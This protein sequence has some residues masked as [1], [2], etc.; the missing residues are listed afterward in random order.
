MA[1]MD[2]LYRPACVP[3]GPTFYVAN[4]SN[5]QANIQYAGAVITSFYYATTPTRGTCF[6]KTNQ[7]MNKMIEQVIHYM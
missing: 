2:M 4:T 6:Q 3:Y 5:K 7:G 1:K